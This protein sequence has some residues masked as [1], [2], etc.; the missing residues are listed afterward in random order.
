VNRHE[1][2][3]MKANQRLPQAD[4]AVGSSWKQWPDP[5]NPAFVCVEMRLPVMS[6]SMRALA[7]TD[8]DAVMMAG[9][10][11]TATCTD[12]IERVGD[13]VLRLREAKSTHAW[14][15]EECDLLAELCEQLGIM[16][17]APKEYR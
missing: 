5:T 15:T 8:S 1:R 11:A 14:T 10:F 4:Y 12:T 7:A 3:A 9:A 17:E 16:Y 6:G 13:L 2:R